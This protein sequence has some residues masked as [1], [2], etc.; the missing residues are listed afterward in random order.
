MNELTSRNFHLPPFERL[1]DLSSYFHLPTHRT[2]LFLPHYINFPSFWWF[3]K[4][5]ITETTFYV[6]FPEAKLFLK[7]TACFRRHHWSA[8]HQGCEEVELWGKWKKKKTV[9]TSPFGSH[10]STCGRRGDDLGTSG[11]PP[12]AA[13]GETCHVAPGEWPGSWAPLLSSEPDWS[14]VDTQLNI[15]VW[16]YFCSCLLI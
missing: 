11:L 10:A 14:P 1:L 7:Y 6:S 4:I 15:S 16:H 9:V 13:P 5:S 12:W 3:I 8:R 2:N